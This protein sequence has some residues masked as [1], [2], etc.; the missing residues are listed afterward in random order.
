[1]EKLIKIENELS[2]VVSFTIIH[3]PRVI[4]VYN[5]KDALKKFASQH[6]A[7]VPD[8]LQT[9]VNFV[10][11]IY[12]DYFNTSKNKLQIF[13]SGFVKLIIENGV[14]TSSISDIQHPCHVYDRDILALLNNLKQ[15]LCIIK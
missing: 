10:C 2:N 14:L 3:H 5:G 12:K 15:I 1:M 8:D 11:V 13:K 7:F 4:K 9:L 6:Y